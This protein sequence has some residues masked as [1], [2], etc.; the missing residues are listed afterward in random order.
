MERTSQQKIMADS[1][2]EVATSRSRAAMIPTVENVPLAR[3]LHQRGDSGGA[4]AEVIGHVMGS[5]AHPP[6][7]AP[8]MEGA[9]KT[10]LK[11]TQIGK[12]KA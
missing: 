7:R 2:Q 6:W 10:R 12:W 4:V 3:A 8:L 1:S 11:C 9:C 5:Q